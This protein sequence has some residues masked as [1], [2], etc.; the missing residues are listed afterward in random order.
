[1]IAALC[2]L[3]QFRCWEDPGVG[4]LPASSEEVLIVAI[5]AGGR[6]DEGQPSD[7]AAALRSAACAATSTR[8]LECE[9]VGAVDASVP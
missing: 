9:K 6:G 2:P 4:A 7:G 1:M 8:L 5:T 3:G